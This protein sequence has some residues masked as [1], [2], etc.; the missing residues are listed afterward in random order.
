M[1][2][3]LFQKGFPT[4]TKDIS[5]K[6]IC[7]GDKV[8]YDFED[9]TSWFI[10]VF[11][12]NAFRKKYPG[13]GKSLEKPLLEYGVAAIRMRLKIVAQQEEDITPTHYVYNPQISKL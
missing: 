12:N 10:V 8:T 13:W 3:R 11:E 1:K 6:K 4:H 5:G 9:N 2:A 7:L